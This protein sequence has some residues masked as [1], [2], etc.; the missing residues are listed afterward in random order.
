M[1]TPETHAVHYMERMTSPQVERLAGRTNLALLPVAPPEAHG[2]HLP[3]G[4]DSI[5]ALELCARAARELAARGTECLIAPLLSYCL[6]E[7]AGPF[8]GTISV[9]PE[10]VT[11]LVADICQ[12]LARSG[13]GRTLI[14]SGHAEEENL[15]ALRAGADQASDGQAR[16]QVSRWYADALPKFFHLL[17]EDHPQHD[18]HAGEWETALVLL[19]A[20]ELVDRGALDALSPNWATRR[21]SERRAGGA[22]TFPEL[23]APEGY[24]GDPRRATAR[25]AEDLYSALGKFVADEG[26]SLL[27]C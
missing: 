9:R 5:A 7:V 20:P 2:P 27:G 4:T 26:A 14:V 1:S 13:F 18:I 25:T 17:R 19:R 21:I 16:A 8:P 24:S 22:R 10:V 12:G 6:A 11:A 15:V 3:L 23:G